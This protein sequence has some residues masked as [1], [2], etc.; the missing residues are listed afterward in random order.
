[1]GVNS[2]PKTVTRPRRDC[3]MN[4]GPSAPESSTLTTRLPSHPNSI[5]ITRKLAAQLVMSIGSNSSSYTAV[6]MY[7]NFILISFGCWISSENVIG[8]NCRYPVLIV[9][10]CLWYRSA[11]NRQFIIVN[12][13]FCM[14]LPSVLWLCWLVGR[15]GIRPVKNG[16]VGC[17]HSYPSGARCRLA[18]GAADATA[19]HCL[20]LQ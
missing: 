20:L 12:A 11:L 13:V 5:V 16:V 17:W 10:H 7:F 18:F 14:V 8:W 2:L 9:L 6:K 19:T 4:P 3:D 1:M 15:K